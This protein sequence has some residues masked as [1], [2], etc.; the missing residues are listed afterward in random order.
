[1]CWSG[2][3]SD[4]KENRHTLESVSA[5]WVL[6]IGHAADQVKFGDGARWSS[7]LCPWKKSVRGEDRDA[8]ANATVLVKSQKGLVAG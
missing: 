5:S 3:G 4:C 1:M 6:R 7:G 2:Y 8:T